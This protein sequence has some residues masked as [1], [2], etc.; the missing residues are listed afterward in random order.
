MY[1]PPE[2]TTATGDDQPRQPTDA[3][4]TAQSLKGAREALERLRRYL[5]ATAPD[6]PDGDDERSR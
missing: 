5:K 2:D 1:R 4:K 6:D 3:E